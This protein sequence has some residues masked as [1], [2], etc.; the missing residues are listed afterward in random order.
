MREA[1][2]SCL[3]HAESLLTQYLLYFPAFLGPGGYSPISSTMKETK[4]TYPGPLFDA[5]MVNLFIYSK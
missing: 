3:V 5:N 1:E 4:P 2:D